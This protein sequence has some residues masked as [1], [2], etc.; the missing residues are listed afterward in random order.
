LWI[1]DSDAADLRRRKNLKGEYCGY[2]LAN[3]LEPI[4]WFL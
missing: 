2:G 4:K 1:E 3:V